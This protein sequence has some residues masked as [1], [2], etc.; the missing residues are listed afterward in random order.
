VVFSEEGE[1]LEG[2]VSDD[3]REDPELFFSAC[4]RGSGD[5]RFCWE[6]REAGKFSTAAEM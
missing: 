1:A 4:G 3:G 2:G 6:D 5:P